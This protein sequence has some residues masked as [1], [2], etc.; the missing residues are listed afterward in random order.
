MQIEFSK[1]Y[2]YVCDNWQCWMY[3]R[4]QQCRVKDP[5]AESRATSYQVRHDIGIASRKGSEGQRQLKLIWR[6]E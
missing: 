3:R 4:P 6:Q 5:E 2:E 1:G